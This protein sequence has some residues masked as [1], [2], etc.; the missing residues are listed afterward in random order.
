MARPIVALLYNNN[1]EFEFN[2]STI[3]QNCN[4][5]NKISTVYFQTI[6]AYSC[7]WLLPTLCIKT[8]SVTL[9]CRNRN[10]VHPTIIC[11]T[12]M[13]EWKCCTPNHYLCHWNE[14]REMLHTQPLSVTL[15]CV[16]G[17]VTH[18][19]IICDIRMKEGKCCTHNHYVWHWNVGIEM[20]HT[21]TL[22][23]TL[24]WR[25]GNIAHPTFICDTGM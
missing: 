6:I 8:L 18:P 7:W 16:N 5:L 9:E 23:A 15:E 21:Q 10:G 24:E 3:T 14:G 22:S 25:K 20:L 2:S 11:D 1:S 19:T 12:G 4:C 17:N 13:C